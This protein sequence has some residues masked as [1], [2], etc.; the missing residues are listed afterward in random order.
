MRGPVVVAAALAVGAGLLLARPIRNIYADIA[1]RGALRYERKWGADLAKAQA[2]FREQRY[3]ELADFAEGRI[4]AHPARRI[5]HQLADSRAELMRLRA[6]ALHRLQK[7]RRTLEQYDQLTAFEPRHFINHHRNGEASLHFGEGARARAAYQAALGIV[8]DHTPS[9]QGLVTI[10]FE[11][12]DFVRAAESFRSFANAL[13]IAQVSLE[14]GKERVDRTW[15]I[16]GRRH[17]AVIPVPTDGT[18]PLV[19]RTVQPCEVEI[20][21]IRVRPVERVGRPSGEEVEVSLDGVRPVYEDGSRVEVPLPHG[22]NGGEVVLEMTLR[23]R[24]TCALDVMARKSYESTLAHEE[25]RETRRR[26]AT[27]CTGDAQ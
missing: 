8:P 9:A 21:S 19:V 14:S 10:D 27:Q 1:H 5:E 22:S 15:P 11:G 18:T 6:L 24:L 23:R 13:V 2:L 16:D 3:Q 26:F 4:A 12:G 20:H 7:K 25:W 17:R